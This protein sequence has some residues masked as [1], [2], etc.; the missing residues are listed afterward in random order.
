MDIIWPKNQMKQENAWKFVTLNRLKL[1]R[2]NLSS[3]GIKT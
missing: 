1:E 3:I 2:D